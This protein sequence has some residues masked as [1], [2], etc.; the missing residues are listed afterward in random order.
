[1]TG[2]QD[3]FVLCPPQTEHSALVLLPGSL[4]SREAFDFYF[5]LQGTLG[6]IFYHIPISID[7]G[8]GGGRVIGLV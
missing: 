1:M 3:A 4:E 7:V 6:T 8:E 5:N 2:C